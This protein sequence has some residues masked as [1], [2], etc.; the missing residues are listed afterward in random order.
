MNL[1]KRIAI[2]A[3]AICLCTSATIAQD[4][5]SGY[6]LDNYTY[7]YQM[8]P[9]FGNNDNGFVGFPALGNI[10]IG[11]H[12]NLHLSDVIYNRNGKT[13]LFT[14]PAVSAAEAM[15]GFSDR[16][17]IGAAF[18]INMINV[19]FKA[20]GGY[21]TVGINMVGNVDASIPKA[22]FSLVK[23]GVENKTYDINDIRGHAEA[24]AEIALNHSRDIKQVPGLR[25]GAA[26]KFLIGVG[27]I[28]A[29]YRDAH[30]VLGQ[31]SWDITANADLYASV[32]N[33]KFKHDYNKEAKREYV[34]GAKLDGFGLNGFGLGFD[35]G[36]EYKWK[37]FRFS[38]A[39]LNLGFISWNQTQHASTDGTVNFK[40]NDYTFDVDS[41]DD[42][43]AFDDMKRDLSAIYQLKDKGN[44][45][46]RTTALAATLNF[47]AN[48]EFPL[49]RRLNFGL[50]NTTRIHGTFTTTQFR[51]SANVKPVD[52]LSASANV[53]C[54]TFG[55]G[56]G[57]LVNLKLHKGFN[58]FVG[59]DQTLGKLAKQGIPLNS[60][61]K[62]NFGIDF[63]F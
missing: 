8:N 51:L 26:V 63:P 47:G 42:K 3:T 18:R 59:M 45:G 56:F 49:Y 21:N 60:N 38:A 24:Y 52:I 58:L 31:D 11:M 33:M 15:E 41:D 34:S 30:L 2:S 55:W 13:V 25:V 9:A 12:G 6:F 29:H 53:A 61:A 36:A 44:S 17:K 28:D 62:V 1:I 5:Y 16:N 46:S 37:D 35:L 19:G 43:D 32:K 50:V 57:W 10:N 20:L 39:V 48:Y 23:E 40:T 7:R 54:G 27:S 14:N 22:F 4:T